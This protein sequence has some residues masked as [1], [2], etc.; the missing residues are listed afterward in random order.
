MIVKVTISPAEHILRFMFLQI[1]KE[2]NAIHFSETF[3]PMKLIIH[4]I[5]SISYQPEGSFMRILEDYRLQ[6]QYEEEL[7]YT[8][9]YLQGKT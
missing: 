4:L 1:I 6:S 7:V 5:K 9:G 8:H 2:K 3:I